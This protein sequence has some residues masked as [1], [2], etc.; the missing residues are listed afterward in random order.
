MRR[1]LTIIVLQAQGLRQSNEYH[2]GVGCTVPLTFIPS[3]GLTFRSSGRT[4]C[5]A[6]LRR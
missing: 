3:P 5:A 2:Y 1:A 6:D 4:A